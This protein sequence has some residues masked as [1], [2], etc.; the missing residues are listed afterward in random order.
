[1]VL[2]AAFVGR[3]RAALGEAGSARLARLIVVGTLP[4]HL[5]ALAAVMTRFEAGPTALMNP[6]HGLRHA[7]PNGWLPPGGP[8]PPL[9]LEILGLITL[10]ILGWR[11]VTWPDRSRRAS[12]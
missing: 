9:V 4:A 10:G 5:W 12:V 11:L 2:A 7:D 8:I 1:V 6:L 3:W